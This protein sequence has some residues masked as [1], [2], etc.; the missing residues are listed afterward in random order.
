MLLQNCFCTCFNAVLES[1][2]KESVYSCA[3]KSTNLP[4]Q[5]QCLGMLTLKGR[6]EFVCSPDPR[7][8]ISTSTHSLAAALSPLGAGQVTGSCPPGSTC[9]TGSAAWILMYHC[10]PQPWW[11]RS[12]RVHCSAQLLLF[13]LIL[14][15]F[16]WTS[17]VRELSNKCMIFL[18]NCIKFPM[19]LYL[20]GPSREGVHGPSFLK[21]KEETLFLSPCNP[22][23]LAGSNDDHL[24]ASSYASILALRGFAWC[25][26]AAVGCQTMALS[27]PYEA[28]QAALS[29]SQWTNFFD[30]PW[31]FLCV[32]RYKSKLL[33]SVPH[34]MAPF[35]QR[36][37]IFISLSIL[38]P[39]QR[40]ANYS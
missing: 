14:S 29:L 40:D 33:S 11:G 21:S 18:E 26:E 31:V 1:V 34:C 38:P 19:R 37:E 27:Q 12:S 23:C 2:G 4:L 24:A 9:R 10:I 16:W 6:A 7:R 25:S 8:C 30:I 35:S 28:G 22:S 36:K 5:S 39:V 32:W 17:S 13:L 15:F 20:A 3:L